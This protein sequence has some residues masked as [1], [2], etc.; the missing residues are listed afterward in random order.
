[1]GH[2]RRFGTT[3]IRRDLRGVWTWNGTFLLLVLMPPESGFLLDLQHKQG[4]WVAMARNS[5]NTWKGPKC[6]RFPGYRKRPFVHKIFVHNFCAPWPPPPPNQ[7]SDGFSL[8]FLLKGPQTELWTLS[9]NCEQTLQKLQTNRI[10]NKR[11]FLR[12]ERQ[13]ATLCLF[14]APTSPPPRKDS[15]WGTQR[16]LQQSGL[17]NRLL[18]LNT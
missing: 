10:M 7:Q 9:Q 18:S 13:F 5:R 2:F 6:A 17:Q 14:H 11:A 1:M 4:F 8:K 3:K 16:R 15:K 12:L